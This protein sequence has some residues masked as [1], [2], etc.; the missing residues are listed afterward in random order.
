MELLLFLGYEAQE[1]ST[2]VGG[3][4]GVVSSVAILAVLGIAL[5]PLFSEAWG[6]RLGVA[7][8]HRGADPAE[9]IPGRGGSLPA[10]ADGD[11][12]ATGPSAGASEDA[13]APAVAADA[14]E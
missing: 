4:A 5:S 14:A 8:E 13:D 10:T 11:A 2:I 6:E 1:L 12:D 3:I 7:T 9:V